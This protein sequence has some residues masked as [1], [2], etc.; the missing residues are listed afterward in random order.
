MCVF[1]RRCYKQPLPH[2]LLLHTCRHNYFR[3]LF[4]Y[5]IENFIENI[6]AHFALWVSRII[7]WV[8]LIFWI[9][10]FISSLS[11]CKSLLCFV[12]RMKTVCELCGHRW[13]SNRRVGNDARFVCE[14]V[15]P[16]GALIMGRQTHPRGPVT[17]DGVR[18]TR[19]SFV[20][21][22]LTSCQTHHKF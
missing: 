4:A 16:Q 12:F 17:M 10:A 5:Y 15:C 18:C 14:S 8:K 6:R 22:I 19:H 7:A 13:K 11:H 21:L 9:H 20:S 2:L 3:R 1:R